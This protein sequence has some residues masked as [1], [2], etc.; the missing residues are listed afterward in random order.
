MLL[1]GV[2]IVS[3]EIVSVLVAPLSLLHCSLQSFLRLPPQSSLRFSRQF[4]LQ[5][6]PQV[7]LRAAL[8]ITNRIRHPT[9]FLSQNHLSHL[10]L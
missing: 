7:A 9:E 4:F 6:V 3:I 2:S 5:V 1:Q 10:R 8:Q